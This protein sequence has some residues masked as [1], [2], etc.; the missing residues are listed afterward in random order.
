MMMHMGA[1]QGL[2]VGAQPGGGL[3]SMLSQ[4]DVVAGLRNN[5]PGN[6]SATAVGETSSMNM[7]MDD[8]W[9]N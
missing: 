2:M 7:G 5:Y 6:T 8:I 1:D 9:Q 3:A 4:E